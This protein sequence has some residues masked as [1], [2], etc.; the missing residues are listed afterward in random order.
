MLFVD[1]AI[2]TKHTEHDLQQMV[3]QLNHACKEFGLTINIKKTKCHGSRGFWIYINQHRWCAWSHRSLYMSCLCHHQKL[4]MEIDKHIAKV[5]TVMAKLS[6]GQQSADLVH[7]TKSIPGMCPLYSALWQWNLDNIHQEKCLESFHFCCVQCI[8]SI[9]WRDK[10]T[11]TAVLEQDSSWS[12]HF[13]LHQYRLWWLGYVHWINDDYTK[14]L[15]YSKLYIGSLF[16]GS[17]QEGPETHRY[18]LW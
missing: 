15:L 6:M 7:Q 17:L 18:C 5:A 12:L 2:L 1:D 8:L 10:V 16:Q 4:D 9:I 14:D 3:S 11:N 13:L